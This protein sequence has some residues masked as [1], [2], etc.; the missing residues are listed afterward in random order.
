MTESITVDEAI[1]EY[2]KLKN[3]YEQDYYANYI[4]GILSN[5][6]SNKEKRRLFS[7][8]PKAKCVNCKRNVGT[9][10]SAKYGT[11]AEDDVFKHYI[12]KCGDFDNPCPLNIHIK[13]VKTFNIEDE[14]I[15]SYND[16]EKTKLEIIK[17]KNNA[18]FFNKDV[19]SIFETL[20]EQLKEDTEVYGS[21][22]ETYFYRNSNPE[23]YDLLKKM[24]DEFGIGYLIPFKELIKE[25]LN[26]GN[27]KKL[28]TAITMYVK[29]M[30]P[31]IKKIQTLK[32]PIN[33]VVYDETTNK[34]FLNQM[35]YSMESKE[36]TSDKFNEV[37][38]FELGVI[39]DKPVIAKEKSDKPKITKPK[40]TKPKTIKVSNKG[41]S[42]AKTLKNKKATIVLEEDDESKQEENIQQEVI[43][44]VMQEKEPNPTIKGQLERISEGNEEE[45]PEEI[46][47]RQN[48]RKLRD[49]LALENATEAL[50]NE[51]KI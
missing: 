44:E 27:E 46:R 39:K 43:E 25:Y 22:M 3:E 20:T 18:I 50:S 6:Q 31:E 17:E 36:Y 29:E 11:E 8:L 13:K 5:A 21:F 32:Y 23:K 30:M 1:N 38:S 42:K 7:M 26:T 15:D 24:I 47:I 12:V 9:N 2:Y 41:V 28:N 34:Y 49:R 10:F 51:T 33:E 4:S 14:S 16:I 19:T 40:I 48:M 37:I 45:S 35:H